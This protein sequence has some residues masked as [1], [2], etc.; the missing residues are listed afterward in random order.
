[1]G[2]SRKHARGVVK[3]HSAKTAKRKGRRWQHELDVIG[4]KFRWKRDGR[5]ALADM[6]VKR[7]SI[8]G[9]RF[10]R[11]PDNRADENAIMVC[12]PERILGGKQLGYLRAETAAVLAPHL[13]SGKTEIVNV[14]LESL[15]EHD[16]WN[17]G[18]MVAYFRDSV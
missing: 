15:D 7:G 16:D 2:T 10:I 3:G 5:R 18:T 9:V 6:I 4:L 14:V 13:D 1:M 11:E 17:S 12:L 8:G